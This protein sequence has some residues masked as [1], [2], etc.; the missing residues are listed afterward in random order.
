MAN[1]L[2]LDND[3]YG[4][5]HEIMTA[6]FLINE[7]PQRPV[8]RNCFADSRKQFYERTTKSKFN[9][10]TAEEYINAIVTHFDLT[11]EQIAIHN[12]KAESAAEVIKQYFTQL[13][14]EIIT[15]FWTSNKNDLMWLFGKDNTNPSDFVVKTKGI[16][17][18]RPT[19]V[20]TFLTGVNLKNH[21]K[22]VTSTVSNLGTSKMDELFESD[23]KDIVDGIKHSVIENTKK[24]GIDVNATVSALHQEEKKIPALHES[25]A[26]IMQRACQKVAN[27]YKNTLHKFDNDKLKDVLI[28]IIQS[29][30]TKIR[31]I[32][33]KSYGTQIGNFKHELACHNDMIK[34]LFDR[35]DGHLHIKSTVGRSITIA[36]KDGVSIVSI[37]IKGKTSGGFTNVTGRVKGILPNAIR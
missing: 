28:K 9:T 22:K 37:G 8:R 3:S 25:N 4:K 19:K 32:H 16:D 18:D 31:C 21:T 12:S 26:Q 10:K 2:G 30:P 15:V 23:T 33:L 27:K 17:P 29:E 24:Y 14:H 7:F 1:I 20:R 5:Y 6:K 36:G 35:H 13:G 34:K 11:A